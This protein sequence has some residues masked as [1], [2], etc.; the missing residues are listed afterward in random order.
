[1]GALSMLESQNY[2]AAAIFLFF[3][4]FVP[5]IDD[6]NKLFQ[7]KLGDGIS[8]ELGPKADR[9]VVSDEGSG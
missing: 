6:L 2:I 5:L 1:M 7:R 9:E 8:S 3:A 4:F